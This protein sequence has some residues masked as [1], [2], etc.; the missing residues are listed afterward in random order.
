MV[1][2]VVRMVPFFHIANIGGR[3][4]G[5]KGQ[6]VGGHSLLTPSSLNN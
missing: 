3:K 2:G 4:G 1:V 6:L 5:G